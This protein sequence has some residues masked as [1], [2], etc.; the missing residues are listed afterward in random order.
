MKNIIWAGIAAV[1]LS[2]GLAAHSAAGSFEDALAAYQRFDY[3]TAMRLW[4]SLADQGNADAQSRLGFMYQRGHGVPRSE[5]AAANWYRKAADQGNA[6]GQVN[7]GLLYEEGRGGLQKDDREATRL[8]K[9]AADQGDAQAQN[10]LG[11]FYLEGRSGL[12]KDDREATRLFKLSADQGNAD[13]QNNLGVSYRDGLGGVSKDDR[14]AARLFKLSADQ[15]NYLAQGN[16]GVMYANGWGVQQDY[17]AAHM[18]LNLSVWGGPELLKHREF[19]AAEMTPEQIAEAEKRFV[20]W[21]LETPGLEKRAALP[22]SPQ[23]AGSARP[24]PIVIADDNGGHLRDYIE[25]YRTQVAAGATFRIDGWCLSACNLVLAWADRVCVTERAAL[26]FHQVSDKSGQGVQSASDLLML[27]YPPPVQ[28]YIS[29]HG[30]LPPPGGM[31]LVRGP[32][33]RG[34]VKPCE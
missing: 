26:V 33:L 12:Q 20:E 21:L 18:W 8:Y 3:S 2:L 4:L 28:E 34:L 29:A 24:K 25:R 14:E 23:P 1:V 6:S 19:V 9:L 11:A 16:L 7:L 27:L 32:A 10:I 15:G 22:A 31:M 30:G 5:V 13:G 17:V